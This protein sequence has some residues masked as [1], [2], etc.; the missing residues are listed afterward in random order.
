M[1]RSSKLT[2]YACMGRQ[3]SANDATQK[4]PSLLEIE[5]LGWDY[6]NKNIRPNNLPKNVKWRNFWQKI[7]QI[8]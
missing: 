7:Y 6:G 1:R 4:F 8:F 5:R 3:K 2:Q